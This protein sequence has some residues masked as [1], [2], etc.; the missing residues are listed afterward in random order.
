MAVVV[1]LGDPVGEGQPLVAG[2]GKE[3]TRNGREVRDVGADEQQDDDDQYDGHPGSRHGL[4]EDVD[5][6]VE[7]GVG[8]SVADVGNVVADRQDGREDQAKVD[9]VDAHHGLWD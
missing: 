9:N 1:D 7:R 6:W 3:V 5:G 2:E 4:S 8:E